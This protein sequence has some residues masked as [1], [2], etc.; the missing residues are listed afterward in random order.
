MSVVGG[1]DGRLAGE[2][3]RCRGVGVG[4]SDFVGSRMG[5]LKGDW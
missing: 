2:E 1:S 3:I 4:M 5:D